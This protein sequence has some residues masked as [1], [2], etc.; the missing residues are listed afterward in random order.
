MIVAIVDFNESSTIV[1]AAHPR[2]SNA[3]ADV[4]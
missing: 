1:H 3:V 4:K 2:A